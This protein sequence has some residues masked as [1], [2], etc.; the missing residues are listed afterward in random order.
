MASDEWPTSFRDDSSPEEQRDEGWRNND[1]LD[2]KKESKLFDGHQSKD[3]LED[4]I[5]ELFDGQQ[6]SVQGL[7][8][9]HKCQQTC[10][11]Y[12]GALRQVIGKVGEGRPD[13]SDAV[14]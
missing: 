2:Q 8:G 11:S 4:P 1:S 14:A 13:R 3:G 7:I 5:D 10:G 9:T 6:P 12:A